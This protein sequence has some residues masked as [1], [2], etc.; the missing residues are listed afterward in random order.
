MVLVA[1][2]SYC[3][4]DGECARRRCRIGRV[5]RRLDGEETASSACVCA[6][7]ADCESGAVAV[8][9]TMRHHH[10][11]DRAVCGSDGR[12]YRNHCE[13]HR[14]ACVTRRRL[15]VN[16]RTAACLGTTR[17]ST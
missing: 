3:Y 17:H 5:C 1:I 9:G 6:E 7:P 13:L 11:R 10:G 15:R 12:W 4:V 16:R 8:S 14:T 2:V